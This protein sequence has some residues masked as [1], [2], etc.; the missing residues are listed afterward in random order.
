MCR[1][2]DDFLDR[3]QQKIGYEFKDE[4]ILTRAL[5]HKSFVNEHPGASEDNQRLEFLGDAVLGLVVAEALM[6]TLPSAAEG[7]LTPK[8]ASLVNEA[9]LAEMAREIEE[10]AQIEAKTLVVN[11]E[12]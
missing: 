3:V 8:R 2:D 6:E 10:R 12:P 4:T 5:T 7:E 11:K 1:D 9:S